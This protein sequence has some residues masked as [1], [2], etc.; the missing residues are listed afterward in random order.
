[1][2]KVGKQKFPYTS[3]GVQKAQKH[4]KATGQKVDMSGYKRGGSPRSRL[5]NKKPTGEPSRGGRTTRNWPDMMDKYVGKK[6]PQSGGRSSVIRDTSARKHQKGFGTTKYSSAAHKREAQRL[7]MRPG[8]ESS[9][10]KAKTRLMQRTGER[11]DVYVGKGKAMSGGRGRAGSGLKHA[12]GIGTTGKGS[13][14]TYSPGRKLGISSKKKGG[15]VKKK[16]HHGGRVMGG[17]KKP[18]N[19]KC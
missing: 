6:T 5:A 11:P 12:L 3:G 14:T 8:Q 18:K 15:A 19:Q 2:P 1:M 7:G 9:V 10:Q 13:K 16:Y 4:A 17:Q